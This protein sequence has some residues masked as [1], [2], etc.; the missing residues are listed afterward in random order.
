M[1]ETNILKTLKEIKEEYNSKY[2]S[3]VVNFIECENHKEENPTVIVKENE[4]I[5]IGT[6]RM[7]FIMKG[8]E[9]N[10]YMNHFWK[11]VGINLNKGV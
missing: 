11:A 5:V 8:N 2:Q 9:T 6:S 1:T 4:I 7:L 3:H 10:P